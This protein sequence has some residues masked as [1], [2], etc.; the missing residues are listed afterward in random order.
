[1]L[2]INLKHYHPIRKL[3]SNIKLND[4]IIIKVLKM[5]EIII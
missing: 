3:I 4:L 1:M 5:C 2:L